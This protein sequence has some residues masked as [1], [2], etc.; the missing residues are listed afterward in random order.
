MS[1]VK[2]ITTTIEDEVIFMV[3]PN[4]EYVSLVKYGAN[5]APF[6]V[7]KSEK[8]K[9]ESNMNKVVQSVLVRNDLSDEDIAKALEGIDKRSEKKF[10]SFTAYPQVDMAKVDSD[11]IVV[12]K[13]EEVD[14][15]YF[16]LG[17]LAKGMTE[18][19]TL[20]IDSKEAVDYA[21]MDQLYTELYAMAD[22]VGGAMRQENADAEFRKTTILTT[23]DNFKAFAEVVLESL[24]EKKLEQGIKVEDHPELVV[25]ILHAPTTAKK[26]DEE[27]AAEAKAAEVKVAEKAEEDRRAALTDE[28]REA[29]DAAAKKKEE[30]KTS[31]TDIDFNA[32]VDKFNETMNNFG[33][34]LVASITE[35]GK[36]AKKS[37]E[38]ITKGLEK[39][40]E[41]VGEVKNTTLAMKAENDEDL[42]EDLDT[43]NVFKGVLFSK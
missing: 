7:L 20:M 43:T 32:F 22:V 25:D 40:T 37:S 6:K 15:I 4:V 41:E 17:D 28:E 8:T 3:N 10:S 18:G 29:E 1:K 42:D 31:D 36:E 5:R 23:I 24:T 14:G 38:A 19:G 2:S 12:T 13:H 16:V 33:E 26:T 11:S 9:E 27:K 34:K 35:M 21:T 39:V 30:D